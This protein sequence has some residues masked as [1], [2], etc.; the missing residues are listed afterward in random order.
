MPDKGRDVHG[1]LGLLQPFKVVAKAAPVQR[2]A[3]LDMS[4][5]MAGIAQRTHRRGAEAALTDDLR[6]H[7]LAD[8]AVGAAIDQQREVG[9]GVNVDESRRHRQARGVQALLGRCLAQV[10]NGG[11]AVTANAD[12]CRKG[13]GARAIND[14]G[15][16]AQN[17]EPAWPAVA[18]V[19]R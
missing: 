8:L 2:D 1:W 18:G 5:Q 14:V 17:V 15:A 7:A 12:I 13:I 3:N 10:A 11:Y 4:D 19:R 6:G 16:V 9:M